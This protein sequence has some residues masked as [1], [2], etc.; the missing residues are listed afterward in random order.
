M[1]QETKPNHFN[2]QKAESSLIKLLEA[3][4]DIEKQIKMYIQKYGI[5]HFFENFEAF[6]FDTN[7]IIKLQAAR[8]VLLDLEMLG[9]KDLRGGELDNA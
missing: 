1:I 5:V 7:T 4:T 2:I 9:G 6:E 3:D 8:D